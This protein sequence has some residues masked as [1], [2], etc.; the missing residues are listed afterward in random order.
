MSG[1]SNLATPIECTGKFKKGDK[2]PYVREAFEYSPLLVG[3]EGIVR[4]CGDFCDGE[5]PYQVVFK[6]HHDN[7]VEYFNEVELE[8]GWLF[9]AGDRVRSRNK[10]LYNKEEGVIVQISERYASPIY[11]VSFGGI[12]DFQFEG[13]N[14]ERVVEVEKSPEQEAFEYLLSQDRDATRS[15]LQGEIAIWA[16]IHLEHRDYDDLRQVIDTLEKLE[17][18]K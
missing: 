15:I 12:S 8:R 16:S 17:E 9:E 2:V 7:C 10:R 6:G 1:K 13:Y 4:E 3:R 18:T 14:L 5:R 11:T